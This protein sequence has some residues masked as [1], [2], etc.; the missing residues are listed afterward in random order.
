MPAHK[1]RK[2]ARAADRVTFSGP[3]AAGTG[4]HDY[5]CA[6][7]NAVVLESVHLRQPSAA[8]FECTQCGTLN[9]VAQLDNPPDEVVE[10]LTR[11]YGDSLTPPDAERRKGTR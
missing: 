3:I 8:V 4:E 11:W 1:L 7:C 6:G 5:H 2:I 9:V 10:R